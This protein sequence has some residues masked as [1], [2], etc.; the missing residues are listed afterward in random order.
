MER[1]CTSQLINA[2][3]TVMIMAIKEA[4]GVQ[5]PVAGQLDLS[6]CSHSTGPVL[7]ALLA[8]KMPLNFKA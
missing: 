2:V 7:Q 1:E 4:K 8:I 6:S 3:I 5:I